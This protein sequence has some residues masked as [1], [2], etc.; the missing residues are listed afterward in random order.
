MR[1]RAARLSVLA[2]TLGL[3]SF[4]GLLTGCTSVPVTAEEAAILNQKLQSYQL[5]GD[6]PAMGLR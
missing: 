6:P 4:T 3:L 5:R 1:R 2:A